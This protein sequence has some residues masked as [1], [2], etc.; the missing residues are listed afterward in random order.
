MRTLFLPLV[1]AAVTGAPLAAQMRLQISFYSDVYNPDNSGGIWNV[2]PDLASYTRASSS[3]DYQD[4]AADARDV[5]SCYLYA[6]RFLNQYLE[7]GGMTWSLPGLNLNC[8]GEG[9]DGFLYGEGYGGRFYRLDFIT[10]RYTLLTTGATVVSDLTADR[11]GILY[12]IAG[13]QLLRIDPATGAKTLVTTLAR[14]FNTMGISH[15]GRFW[16]VETLSTGGFSYLTNHLYQFDPITGTT[17][18]IMNLPNC[19]WWN[20][21]GMSSEWGPPRPTNSVLLS[22]PGSANVGTAAVFS[23]S[24]APANGGFFLLASRLLGLPFYFG[25]PFELGEPRTIVAT[26]NV[27]AWGTATVSVQLHGALAGR[28]IRFEAGARVRGSMPP[29][30]YDSNVHSVA[31]Q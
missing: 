11:F 28:T 29:L 23:I 24:S 5:R 13:N 16:G 8:I 1:L 18:F 10:R 27:D 4:L 17:T 30:V 6:D 20:H 14:H 3:D 2:Y 7:A 31:V 9:R 26:G 21:P 22:G 15:D 12:G 25:Q 19:E